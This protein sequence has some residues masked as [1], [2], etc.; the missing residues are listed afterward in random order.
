MDGDDLIV[1]GYQAFSVSSNQLILSSDPTK[2]TLFYRKLKYLHDVYGVNTLLDI[3]S[4]AGLI[5]LMAHFCGY[6][7]QIY[8]LDHDIEYINVSRSIFY[9]RKIA[10]IS[11]ELFSFG[12][13][14]PLRYRS[15]VVVM[16]AVLHWIFSCTAIL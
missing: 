15:E 4:N 13:E 11:V 1:Q 8:G 6:S 12:D 10:N 3:G 5:L 9:Q 7:G 16:G 14:L 2:Y